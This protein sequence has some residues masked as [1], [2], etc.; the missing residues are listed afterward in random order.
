MKGSRIQGVEGSSELLD[1]LNPGPLE[2]FL[3]TN[4]EK[5]YMFQLALDIDFIRG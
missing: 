5:N 1:P 3:S 2:P 4:W